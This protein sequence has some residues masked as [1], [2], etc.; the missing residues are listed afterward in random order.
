MVSRVQ[1]L[2]YWYNYHGGGMPGDAAR[3]DG[4]EEEEEEEEEA[5]EEE[6]ES[7]AVTG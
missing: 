7:Q 3:E 5:E 2:G 4:V 6:E 1:N